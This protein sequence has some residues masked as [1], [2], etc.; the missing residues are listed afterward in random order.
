MSSQFMT[1]AEHEAMRPKR[2]EEDAATTAT[3]ASAA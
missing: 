1:K 2:Y 3:P